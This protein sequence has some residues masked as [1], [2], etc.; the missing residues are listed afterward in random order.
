MRTSLGVALLLFSTAAVAHALY[1]GEE[2]PAGEGEAAVRFDWRSARASGSCSGSLVGTRTVLTAA[3][4]LR[5]STLGSMRVTSV[6]IGNPAGATRTVRVAETHV[7]PAFDVERPEHGNDVA[8][9]VLAEDVTDR[10][11]LRLATANDDPSEQGTR[12]RIEGFGLVRR[13]GR[14][15]RSRALRTASLEYLSPFHCFSGD[16]EGMARNRMCA[17][18]PEAGVCPGDSGSAATRERDGERIV[19]GVVSLAIDRSTCSETATVLTRVS[20]MRE[21]LDGLVR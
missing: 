11:P 10:R 13:N 16:V 5:S 8:L 12:I 3:H 2:V 6:R 9:L 19:V 17:A 1:G 15:V 20:A 7:H 18:S 4:C 21:F 14:T